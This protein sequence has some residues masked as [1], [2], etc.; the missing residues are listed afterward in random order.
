MTKPSIKLK[1][2]VESLYLFKNIVSNYLD[3]MLNKHLYYKTFG[4]ALVFQSSY[5]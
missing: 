5:W 4:L 3:C 2:S 1:F